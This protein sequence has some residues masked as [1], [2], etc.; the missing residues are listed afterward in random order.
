MSTTDSNKQK[1][2]DDYKSKILELENK[3]D[4]LGHNIEKTG[5]ETIKNEKK[6]KARFIFEIITFI[7]SII[8]ICSVAFTYFNSQFNNLRDNISK[9]LTEDDIKDLKDT[10][11]KLNLWVEGDINDSSK[12]GANSRL[13]KIEETLNITPINVDDSLVLNNLIYPTSME[14]KTNTMEASLTLDTYIGKD[15]EG[16]TYSVQDIVSKK[17]LL[18]YVEGNKEVYFLGQ[19][20]DKYHWHG[21]CVTNTYNSDGTLSGICESNFND[22][23]RLDYNSFYLSD[24][25]DEWIHT[26]RTCEE[27]GNSGT[28]ARYDYK[29]NITKNFTNT[30]VKT[31]DLLYIKDFSSSD[32]KV[33]L[34]YYNGYTSNGKYNDLDNHESNSPY[35]VIFS[36]DG[37]VEKLY[38]GQ[39]VNG[40]FHDQSGNAQELVFD[41][42]Y[43]INKYFYYKGT[44]SNGNRDGNVSSK[45]YVTQD[46]IDELLAGK[47]FGVELKWYKTDSEL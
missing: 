46:E 1:G 26:D 10:V 22:G 8:S 39:F 24:T 3:I 17:A 5:N 14:D 6:E 13:E 23:K 28:T 32:D 9:C 40:L 31:Y 42:S 21:Y 33:L 4:L 7:F 18:T 38:M 34:T 36:S 41:T 43:N 25:K 37:T 47:K 15:S 2:K 29:C 35:E 30:N 12:A 19:L 11:A 27:D 20:N 45:N 44:F 16:N